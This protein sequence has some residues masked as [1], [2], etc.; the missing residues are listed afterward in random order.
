MALITAFL[1]AAIVWGG[2]VGVVIVLGV[3]LS[4]PLLRACPTSGEDCTPTHKRIM[5]HLST[6]VRACEHIRKM[7]TISAL[8]KHCASRFFRACQTYY[9]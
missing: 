5:N 3:F 6:A 8:L 1:Q 7:H 2:A 4:V 9:S